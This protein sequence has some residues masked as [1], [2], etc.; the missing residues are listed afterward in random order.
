MPGFASRSRA[1]SSVTARLSQPATKVRNRGPE[2]IRTTVHGIAAFHPYPIETGKAERCERLT[3]RATVV[4]VCTLVATITIVHSLVYLSIDRSI[5]PAE[6]PSDNS[7]NYPANIRASF[8]HHTALISLS[9]RRPAC[10]DR[11][12]NLGRGQQPVQCQ[13]RAGLGQ[14]GLL[15]RR[16]PNN[17]LFFVRTS[18]LDADKSD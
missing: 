6:M 2:L 7:K 13:E 17:M 14:P 18:F 3:L 8:V 4:I 9:E 16:Q 11:L 5:L 1:V 12:K 15:I 10:P